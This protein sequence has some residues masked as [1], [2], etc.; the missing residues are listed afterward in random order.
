ML[1]IGHEV[2]RDACAI[3]PAV[4]GFTGGRDDSASTDGDDVDSFHVAWHGYSFRQ[5]N[6]LASIA[7]EKGCLFHL[8]LLRFY[9]RDESKG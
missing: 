4:P 9:W 8:D 5:A 2:C 1:A 7:H 3:E 6:G